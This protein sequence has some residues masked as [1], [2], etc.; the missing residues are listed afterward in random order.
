MKDCR[1]ALERGGEKRGA[2]RRT[3]GDTETLF[4]SAGGF[5][6]KCGDSDPKKKPRDR[7]NEMIQPRKILM[8]AGLKECD[9]TGNRTLKEVF[10]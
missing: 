8:L 7:R 1:T 4:P 5:Q 3:A 10:T 2:K 6:G 9:H